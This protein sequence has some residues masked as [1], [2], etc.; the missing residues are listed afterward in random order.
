MYTPFLAH[1][2]EHVGVFEQYARNSE[3]K[4]KS[5]VTGWWRNAD[6]STIQQ[7]NARALY[8]AVANI[9]SKTSLDQSLYESLDKLVKKLIEETRT[10]VTR[11]KGPSGNTWLLLE[12]DLFQTRLAHAYKNFMKND[13]FDKTYN[14]SPLI[15]FKTVL[16]TYLTDNE[17]YKRALHIGYY[18]LLGWLWNY[19]FNEDLN[20]KKITI[21]LGYLNKFNGT[22]SQDT[23][24][25]AIRAQ[26]TDILREESILLD[27]KKI[28]GTIPIQFGILS[29]GIPVDLIYKPKTLN[30]GL[31]AG[32]KLME[33][34]Q[35]TEAPII[36]LTSLIRE[37]TSPRSEAEPSHIQST[38]QKHDQ[39]EE[40]SDHGS[41]VYYS[42]DD[43][44]SEKP[45]AIA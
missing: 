32:L 12:L 44:P 8:A 35:F 20:S 23:S 3:A 5:Y 39:E 33:L 38:S 18:N 34:A 41:V 4:D 14:N 7:K 40:E 25:E 13:L 6:L 28:E 9:D 36:R 10:A 2:I 22:T 31:N 30:E 24:R 29:S 1:L 45:K 21:V 26:F 15:V 11:H 16:A 19:T 37:N 42:D 27:R 17:V 43:T